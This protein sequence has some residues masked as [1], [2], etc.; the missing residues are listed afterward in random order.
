ML[1]VNIEVAKNFI[2]TSVSRSPVNVGAIGS[3]IVDDEMPV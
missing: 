3:F 1:F 2:R